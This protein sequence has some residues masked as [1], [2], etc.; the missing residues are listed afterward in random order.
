[1]A[2][3]LSQGDPLEREFAEFIQVWLPA[4][5]ELWGTFIGNDGASRMPEGPGISQEEESL[6]EAVNTY[7][8]TALESALCAHRLLEN[9]SL[10]KLPGLDDRRSVEQYL[11][12]LNALIA[13]FAQLGRIRDAMKHIGDFVKDEDLW[14]PLD[15][16]YK[17]R[18]SLLHEAKAPVSIN[19]GVLAIIPLRGHGDDRARWGKSSTWEAANTMATPVD[20]PTLLRET[21]EG[22]LGVLNDGCARL[23]SKH[24][25]VRLVS[26][27]FLDRSNNDYSTHPVVVPSGSQVDNGFE[28]RR[29]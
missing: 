8:Y 27:R 3:P 25:R 17:Q 14:R 29:R 16:Y 15:A 11:D 28:R 18:S 1:M 19:D 23:S 21:L 13:L 20:V 9:E 2:Q 12:C 24:L 7:A 22:A 6:R 5:A 10:F 4:Y 26:P